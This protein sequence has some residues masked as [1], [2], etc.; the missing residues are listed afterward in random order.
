MLSVLVPIT[1]KNRLEQAELFLHFLSKQTLQTFELIFVEQVNALLG[2]KRTGGP[3]YG[4]NAQYKHIQIHGSGANH[5]NQP[6]MANVGARHAQGDKFLF[7]DIDVVVDETYLERVEAFD[8]PYFFTYDTIHMLTQEGSKMIQQSKKIVPGACTGAL[9][10]PSGAL[11]FAGFAVCAQRDFFFNALGGY[12]ENY[13][14]WGG[15]DNDIAWRARHILGKDYRLPGSI[16]HIWHQRQYTEFLKWERKSIW[17]TTKRNPQVV[18]DRLKKA[19]LGKDQDFTLI[20]IND[21]YVDAAA[22]RLKRK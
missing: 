13:F 6:W 19:N 8:A 9:T 20:D 1:G 10:G 5:F 14:G 22:E 15:N 12:N 2:G 11:D 21:I 17:L 18:T 3:Y 4:G 16:Y 7:M